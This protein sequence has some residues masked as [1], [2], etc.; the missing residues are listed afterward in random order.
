M[1]RLDS[2]LVAEFLQ[3]GRG[4]RFASLRAATCRMLRMCDS[5][6]LAES[7]NEHAAQAQLGSRLS[8]PRAFMLVCSQAERLSRSTAGRL[9]RAVG[10]RRD[11]FRHLAGRTPPVFRPPRGRHVSRARP[12]Y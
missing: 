10:G 1:Q 2:R 11:S 3:G 5:L 4:G 7:P 9:D 6:Q 12:R 8:V